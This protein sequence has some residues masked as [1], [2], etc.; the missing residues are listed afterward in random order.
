VTPGHLLEEEKGMVGN[1]SGVLS[2]LNFGL[3]YLDQKALGLCHSLI[4]G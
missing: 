4:L 2:C 1:R 3:S